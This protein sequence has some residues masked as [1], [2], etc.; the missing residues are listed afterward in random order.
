[1]LMKRCAAALTSSTFLPPPDA[2]LRLVSVAGNE[3]N[4]FRPDQLMLATSV[5][6]RRKRYGSFAA[7]RAQL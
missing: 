1:M 7:E 6:I 3:A 4:V 2:S 5:M